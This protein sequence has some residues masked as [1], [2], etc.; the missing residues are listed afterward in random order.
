MR[1]RRLLVGLALLALSS[2]RVSTSAAPGGDSFRVRVGDRQQV[3]ESYTAGS[4]PT[5]AT[6][7]VPLTVQRFRGGEPLAVEVGCAIESGDETA[8]SVACDAGPVTLGPAPSRS[9]ADADGD[10]DVD[11]QD[12]D[13]FLS[14]YSGDGIPY[15]QGTRCVGFDFDDDLD[16]DDADRTAFEAAYTGPLLTPWSVQRTL[17][18]T[19]TA[20]A[21]EGAA[22]RVRVSASDP[23][24]G[25]THAAWARI[26]KSSFGALLELR[27]RLD[28]TVE[29]RSKLIFDTQAP[30][31]L[32]V[33]QQGAD[34]D[35]ISMSAGTLPAS[36]DFQFHFDPVDQFGL[37]APGFDPTN[38]V[39]WIKRLQLDVT[40][41][42]W[43]SRRERRTIHVSAQSQGSGAV[44]SLDL[45]VVKAGPLWTPS[46]LLATGGR[47]HLVRPGQR[48]TFVLLLTNIFVV[49]KTFSL[50]PAKVSGGPGWTCALS[51]GS[52]DL[53]PGAR[54]EVTATLT[55]PPDALAGAVA[56]WNVTLTDKA[57]F[58]NVSRL[59]A[60][61]TGM[62]KV[63]YVAVDGLQP[64]YLELNA[65]GTGPG[66]VGDWLM[67]NVRSFMAAATTY[68]GARSSLPTLT[69]PNHVNALAGTLSG[70][71]GIP[72]VRTAYYGRDAEGQVV[73][74]PGD[75][76]MLRYG[77][78]GKPVLTAFDVV[79]QVQPRAFTAIA[80]GKNW[81]ANYFQKPVGGVDLVVNGRSVPPYLPPP[82][83]YVLGDPPSD[84]DAA[85]D[86]PRK[87][88]FLVEWGAHPGAFPDDRWVMEGALKVIENE[89]PDLLYILLGGM[90][91]GQHQMGAAW[92]PAEWDDRGTESTWDD[93]SRINPLASREE[94]L[95]LAR[96]VDALFGEL[97]AY[98]RQRGSFDQ[99]YLVFLA[100]HGM[101]TETPP[102]L[103]IRVPLENAGFGY[104]DA[105]LA[106]SGVNVGVLYG[107]PPEQE[108]IFESILENAASMTPGSAVNPWVVM[109]R[110]EMQT[111]VDLHTGRRLAAPDELYSE[112]YAEHEVPTTDQ[113]RWP[114]LYVFFDEPWQSAGMQ[115][116]L[117]DDAVPPVFIGGHGGVDTQRIPLLLHGPRVPRGLVL[118]DPVSIADIA[119]TLYRLQRW[120]I[121]ASVTGTALPGLAL[122]RALAPPAGRRVP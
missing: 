20:A 39:P 45:E 79:K 108:G 5:T 99:T 31:D 10:G 91:N 46:D 44:S 17:T 14:C 115:M 26:D 94:V 12:R 77:P 80:T 98:L 65:H 81:I 18:V 120:P 101:I 33:T 38:A 19:A 48:T 56:D 28:F 119:P 102:T 105:F 83:T 8:W 104:N 88:T 47:R 58:F 97:V 68:T 34:P 3:S 24:S 86:P 61:V 95:D 22:L 7:S 42:A 9:S 37:E 85:E 118:A 6:I 25:E 40:A 107:I 73:A 1:R 27:E 11:Q 57:S 93:V 114:S 53:T 62:R 71:A 50:I 92:N 30:F 87:A 69:D 54:T 112:F 13:A 66:R 52:V 49:P 21:P 35:T 4:L 23:L 67:P 113:V 41:P 111:G 36:D 74:R 117:E 82:P 106:H 16:V 110:S 89:D 116:L 122:R 96:E 72:Y 63:I 70:G 51:R 64:D 78:T 29:S 43:W 59:G 109:N 15:P 76:S 32:R 100:D 103:D 121:P 60:E 2:G 75:A 55:A 84:A 90:D